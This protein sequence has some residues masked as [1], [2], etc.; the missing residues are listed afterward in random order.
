M[1]YHY[2]SFHF[3]NEV[4]VHI[5]MQKEICNTLHNIFKLIY[6]VVN[7]CCIFKLPTYVWVYEWSQRERKGSSRI[8]QVK[9]ISLGEWEKGWVKKNLVWFYKC[10]PLLRVMVSLEFKKDLYCVSVC[11]CEYTAPCECSD[12]GGQK[13]TWDPLGLGLQMVVS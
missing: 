3:L 13:R 1:L 11:L 4:N 9:V 5:L 8:H 7:Q 2:F 10:I 6:I 12:N